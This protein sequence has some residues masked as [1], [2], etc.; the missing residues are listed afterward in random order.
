MN[1]RLSEAPRPAAAS[2]A[3]T[4][5]GVLR[6]WQGVAHT[7]CGTLETLNMAPSSVTRDLRI[8]EPVEL[9]PAVGACRGLPCPQ[10]LQKETLD[11]DLLEAAAAVGTAA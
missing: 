4:T 11:P 10:R 7:V 1:V 2:T 6:G 8:S 5:Y 9:S 3:A